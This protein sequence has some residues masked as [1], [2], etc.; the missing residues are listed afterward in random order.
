MALQLLKEVI[1]AVYLNF[2]F[3]ACS[4]R[5]IADAS[6]DGVHSIVVL[7]WWPVFLQRR[8]EWVESEREASTGL[9]LAKSR[10]L[11]K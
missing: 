9:D 3:S 6:S 11:W 7:W 5:W 1:G 2:S 10:H 4:W 8:V